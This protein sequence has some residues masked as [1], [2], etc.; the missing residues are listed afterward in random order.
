LGNTKIE[1]SVSEELGG[2][3][4]FTRELL[5]RRNERVPGLF[6]GEP[7]F[8]LYIELQFGLKKNQDLTDVN[9]ALT[10][11]RNW[12]AC[13]NIYKVYKLSILKMIPTA[14]SYKNLFIGLKFW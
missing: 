5:A 13:Y 11:C 10:W 14:F 12:L 4:F 6:G 1:K 2:A 3:I 8:K 7:G 9:K